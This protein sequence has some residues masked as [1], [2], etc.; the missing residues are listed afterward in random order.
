MHHYTF[1]PQNTCS[2]QIDL[3]MEDG[4]VHNLRYTGGCNGNLK[5]LGILCEG[6]R[7][8]D[9]V[10]KLTGIRCGNNVTSCGDQLA[11]GLKTLL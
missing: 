9:I 4:V 2:R 1:Y 8:Q 10:D 3:D 7:A 5:A 6:M 11:R